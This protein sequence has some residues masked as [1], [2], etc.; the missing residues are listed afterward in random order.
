[1]ILRKAGHTS[2][3][4]SGVKFK[5]GSIYCAISA[6]RDIV[7]GWTY[8]LRPRLVNRRAITTTE[9]G[10]NMQRQQQQQRNSASNESV[11]TLDASSAC[12]IITTAKRSRARTAVTLNV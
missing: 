2:A 6:V 9:F 8:V 10:R 12:V 5:N 7:T 4:S 1:M 3:C 11:I